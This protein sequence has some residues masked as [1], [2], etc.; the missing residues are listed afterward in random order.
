LRADLLQAAAD[1][2]IADPAVIAIAMAFPGGRA[3]WRGS[4]GA[5]QGSHPRIA[6]A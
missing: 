5:R 3:L 6:D 2:D 1:L 4:K